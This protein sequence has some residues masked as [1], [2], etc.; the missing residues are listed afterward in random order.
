MR[1]GFDAV[2]KEFVFCDICGWGCEPDVET[3][4]G[5][6]DICHR[7]KPKDIKKWAEAGKPIYDPEAP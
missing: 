4:F 1:D 6:H 5:K 2:G 3:E 7:H